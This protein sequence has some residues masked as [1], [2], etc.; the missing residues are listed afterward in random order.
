MYVIK[1]AGATRSFDD[2]YYTSQERANAKARSYS[3]QYNHT[4]LVCKVVEICS[5]QPSSFNTNSKLRDDEC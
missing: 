4:F 5:F 1:S 2:T 3:E